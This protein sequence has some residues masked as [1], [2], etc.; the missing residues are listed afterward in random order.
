VGLLNFR[1]PIFFFFEEAV[2]GVEEID[3]LLRNADFLVGE[4]FVPVHR[5]GG[6]AFVRCDLFLAGVG[7][8]L[9]SGLDGFVA[10]VLSDQFG[11]DSSDQHLGGWVS[12]GTDEK[13]G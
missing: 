13:C 1:P 3:N 4:G 10:D 9:E 12:Q 2:T 8:R 11:T 5:S 6:F 7:Q